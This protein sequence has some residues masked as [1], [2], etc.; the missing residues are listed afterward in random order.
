M[1]QEIRFLALN[2]VKTWPNAWNS[3]PN[4]KT[5]IFINLLGQNSK[6]P[7]KSETNSALWKNFYFTQNQVTL[8]YYYFLVPDPAGHMQT[9]TGRRGKLPGK[10]IVHIFP[11]L[12][13]RPT[14]QWCFNTFSVCSRTSPNC[15]MFCR[16]K[17][18]HLR[19][20]SFTNL[21]TD[22]TKT[23]NEFCDLLYLDFICLG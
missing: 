7:V 17:L 14:K 20:Q 4:Q 18:R 21:H 2:S 6:I 13:I 8:P 22:S 16:L 5:L 19:L 9:A 23:A 1:T 12:K 3:V 10:E 11:A 15:L